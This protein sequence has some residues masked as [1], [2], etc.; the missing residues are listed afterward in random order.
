MNRTEQQQGLIN[1]Q[2]FVISGLRRS[3]QKLCPLD[4]EDQL[5]ILND[6]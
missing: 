1:E 3:I 6:A 5:F 2:Q 4:K